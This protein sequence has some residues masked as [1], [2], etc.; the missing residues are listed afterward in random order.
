[1][2]VSMIRQHSYT[3]FAVIPVSILD[4]FGPKML[5]SSS[6]RFRVGQFGLQGCVGECDTGEGESR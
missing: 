4:S 1:M 5:A 3:T 6:L 2:L